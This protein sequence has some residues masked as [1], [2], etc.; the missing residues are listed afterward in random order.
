MGDHM[1]AF[2]RHKILGVSKANVA[3]PT[4][5][6]QIDHMV[7]GGERH[8]VPDHE[9]T[10]QRLRQLLREKASQLEFPWTVFVKDA[11]AQL[12]TVMGEIDAA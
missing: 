9:I 11:A 3:I 2:F 12:I 1:R 7:D 6:L 5:V 4:P 10:P 8:I